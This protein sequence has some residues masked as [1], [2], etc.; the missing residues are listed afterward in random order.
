MGVK[1]TGF[2]ILTWTLG[3]HKSLFESKN[4]KLILAYLSQASP[5]QQNRTN[6]NGM[7]EH[8]D[9]QSV[10]EVHMT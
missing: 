2:N 8:M 1:S 9:Q 4:N 5:F 6:V 7:A 10:C 3:L